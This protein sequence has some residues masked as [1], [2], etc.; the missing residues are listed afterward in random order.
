MFASLSNLQSIALKVA[1]VY[2]HM[3]GKSYYYA[4]VALLARVL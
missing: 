4:K 1:L 3:S 2:I